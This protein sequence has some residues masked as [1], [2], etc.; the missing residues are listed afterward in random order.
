MQIVRTRNCFY[1]LLTNR[2][3]EKKTGRVILTGYMTQSTQHISTRT[4]TLYNFT[5]RERDRENERQRKKRKLL[6]NSNKS[7]H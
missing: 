4:V 7:N 2:L 5:L 6:T 1:D 3:R